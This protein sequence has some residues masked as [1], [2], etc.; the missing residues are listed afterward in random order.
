VYGTVTKD[1]LGKTTRWEFGIVY[2][3][4]EGT[5]SGRLWYEITARPEEMITTLED[6]TL[7]TNVV[8]TNIG[9][10][11]GDGTGTVFGTVI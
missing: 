4:V 10:D 2:T 11:Q 9:S 7:E 3:I 8:G 1:V 5:E 6:S